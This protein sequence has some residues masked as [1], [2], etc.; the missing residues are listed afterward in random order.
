MTT[1]RLHS[2][3]Q[4]QDPALRWVLSFLRPHAGVLA[5]IALSSLVAVAIGL[6]QPTLTRLLIDDAL[7]GRDAR[8]LVGLCAAMVGLAV[9]NGAFGAWNRWLYIKV[10]SRVLFALRE[11]LYR[12]LLT[13]SPRFFAGN[14]RGDLLTRLDGDVGE[15]LRFAVDAP[16]AAFNAVILLVGALVLMLQLSPSLT[17]LSLVILPAQFLF[18]RWMRPIVDRRTRTLRERS[19]DISTFLV[20]TL[21]AVKLIQAM[22]A[23]KREQRRLHGLTDSYSADLLRLQLINFATGNIPALLGGIG[24]AAVFVTG[25]LMVLD[26]GFTLGALIAFSAYLG[27]ATGPLQSLLSLY[28]GLRRARVSLDRVAELT[29]AQPDITSPP[30]PLPLPAHGG[31]TIVLEEVDFAHDPARPLLRQVSM[32]IAAGSK[33]VLVGDSGA[34]KSTL[35]DLLPRFA[36][37]QGG[38]ILLD[39][40]DLR[41]LDL[42]ALRHRV[43]VMSQEVQLF[44]GSIG[45]NIRYGAPDCGPA[46]VERAARAAQLADTLARL[47]QGLDTPVGTDGARL[48]G[49]ERQRI[50]LARCL[51]RDPLVLVLDEPTSA[52]DDDTAAELDLAV[53]RLFGHRTR[54]VITHR[55]QNHRHA[56]AVWRLEDGR[57]HP[58]IAEA[59]A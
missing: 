42:G 59:C 34:G 58:M 12:H 40:R 48:S 5:V 16:L 18:L 17:A 32:T 26:G 49:G 33:T 51:L 35:V 30:V 36:D 8:L 54:I 46:E 31:G 24:N 47:P 22:G 41:Q 57:L 28:V 27:R 14:R 29:R 44:A 15:I 50:A 3:A 25:G 43:A 2:D 21:G 13:L 23:E 11:D 39:G 45:D 56:N 4:G 9:V 38:R 19:G 6:A 53:D 20:E 1:A 7:Y 10:S 37:P 55:P 52:L